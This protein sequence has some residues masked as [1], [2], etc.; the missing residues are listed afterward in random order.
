MNFSVKKGFDI[1]FRFRRK[2]GCD[3]LGLFVI[4]LGIGFY[5]LGGGDGGS[6]GIWFVCFG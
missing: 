2:E 5:I 3:F 1:G 6:Y 4:S